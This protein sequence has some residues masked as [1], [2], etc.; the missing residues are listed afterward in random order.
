MESLYQKLRNR[1]FEIIAVNLRESRSTVTA[2]MRQY[3]LSFP[4]VLD[5]RGSAGSMYGVRAIPTTYIIDKRGLIV[6]QLVGSIE[7]DTPNVIAAF[8]SLFAE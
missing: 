8:E 3:N 4:A 7:W 1:G 2:F 6:A 5:L